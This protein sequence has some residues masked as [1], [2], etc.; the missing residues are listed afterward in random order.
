MYQLKLKKYKPTYKL[1]SKKS[2]SC[3]NT[4]SKQMIKIS[5]AF[6]KNKNK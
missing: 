3:I 2:K 5:F 1:K 4:F 6:F